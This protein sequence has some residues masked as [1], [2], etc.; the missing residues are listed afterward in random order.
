MLLMITAAFLTVGLNNVN[1]IA[2][3]LRHL[4]TVE[5]SIKAS[6]DHSSDIEIVATAKVQGK[7]LLRKVIGTV[8][9]V[10]VTF[11]V[12]SV[13]TI[14]YALAQAFPDN[15]SVCD[16][17]IDCDPCLSVYSHIQT[18]IIHQPAFQNIVIM[19][20]SPLTLLVALWGMS[21]GSAGRAA[22]KTAQ[23]GSDSKDGL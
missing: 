3:A 23:N 5:S 16:S 2:A 20:A 11:V 7:L 19:L 1:I 15:G 12:R 13:F 4:F 17:K 18:F 9:F 6:G 14:M 10:F 22:N 8:F 21:G